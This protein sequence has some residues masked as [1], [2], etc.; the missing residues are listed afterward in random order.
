M[1]KSFFLFAFFF[2]ACNRT[3]P[4]IQIKDLIK[5]QGVFSEKLIRVSGCVQIGA[6]TIVMK[7]CSKSYSDEQQSIWLDS[8]ESIRLRKDVLGIRE[9]SIE[10]RS[11]STEEMNK[12][13]QFFGASKGSSRYA[14]LEGE[15][16]EST[17]A[18]YGYLSSFKK[19]LIVHRVLE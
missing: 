2:V 6:E 17:I 3:L 12:V 1:K 10:S 5:S 9:Y 16:Q 8:F 13:K 19:R 14:I 7:E 18:K 15:Y 4:I 11:N